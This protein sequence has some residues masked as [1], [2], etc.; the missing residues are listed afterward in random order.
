MGLY[1]I[2]HGEALSAYA[3]MRHRLGLLYHTP[4][5]MGLL[6]LYV[7]PS[8]V[9]AR[10]IYDEA[11]VLGGILQNRLFLGILGAEAALQVGSRVASAYDTRPHDMALGPSD[12]QTGMA[13]LDENPVVHPGRMPIQPGAGTS[14]GS[15]GVK[16]NMCVRRCSSCN[17]GVRCS[18]QRR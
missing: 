10:K 7:S 1:Q 2:K 11:D 4:C 17:M 5:A 12:K 18:Q 8:Q 13:V 14:M 16:G 3:L 6:M 9:N 15:F